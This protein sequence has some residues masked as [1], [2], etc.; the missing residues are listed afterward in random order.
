VTLDLG[1]VRLV[2]GE[3]VVRGKGAK[4]RAPLGGKAAVAVR[5]FRPWTAAPGGRREPDSAEAG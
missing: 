2:S 3:L 4:M 1:D 5:R